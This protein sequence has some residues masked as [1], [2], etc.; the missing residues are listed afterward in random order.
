MKRHFSWVAPY[1]V[2]IASIL[3]LVHWIN[4]GVTTMAENSLI[5]RNHTIA[6]DAGH[7]FP[8]GGAISCTGK[9]ESEFNLEI[10][11]RLQD[12]MH[13]MGLET[14]MVRT[15]EESIYTHGSTI[16]EKKRSDL[17]ERVRIVNDLINP[18]L[19]SIHQ[20]HFPDA[21]YKGAVVLYADTENS[22]KLANTVQEA[23]V[24]TINQGSK[25]SSK[26]ASGIYL[27]EHIDC[28]GI[29]V[30]CGF[31][32]NAVEEAALRS[33]AYQ[34]QISCII[35]CAVLDF[36]SNHEQDNHFVKILKKSD[37]SK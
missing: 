36:L 7:G 23:F 13:L 33:E 31:L 27:M 34:K 24:Q 8:D 12:L 9:P 22:K 35:T 29:L 16:S 10:A 19:I 15:S 30:E 26:A 17:Q 32:S 2:T 1:T 6:I 18:I 4:A 20:N 37:G 14:R 11:A 3:V 21:Q 28:P 25:R 5:S